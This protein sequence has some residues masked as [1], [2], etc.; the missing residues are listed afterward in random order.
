MTLGVLSK[1]TCDCRTG[2]RA[3]NL[4]HLY[5]HF[6]QVLAHLGGRVAITATSTSV[7]LSRSLFPRGDTI[8]QRDRDG[9]P[10]PHQWNTAPP[11][12]WKPRPAG[13][14]DTR[15][16]R[17]FC[18]FFAEAANAY[19]R[20]TSQSRPLLSA[21]TELITD[22]ARL[23][24]RPSAFALGVA[25]RFIR[26]RG[27]RLLRLRRHVVLKLP[28]VSPPSPCLSHIFISLTTPLKTIFFF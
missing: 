20:D 1:P 23:L 25:Y 10:G 3:A 14:A 2:F 4:Q 17:I 27:R 24:S 7:A 13:V 22:Y 8:H 9:M 21:G 15:Y 26:P 6:A 5:W 28:V 18:T 16:D 19:G 11:S 12:H